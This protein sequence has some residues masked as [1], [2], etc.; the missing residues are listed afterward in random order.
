M[1]A[2]GEGWGNH[3]D[4]EIGNSFSILSLVILSVSEESHALGYEILRWRSE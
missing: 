2:R 3:L 4:Y 1:V